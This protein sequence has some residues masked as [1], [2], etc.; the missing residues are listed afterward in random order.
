MDNELKQL[1]EE[2]RGFRPLAVPA[3]LLERIEHDLAP[4]P[5]RWK[6]WIPI[7]VLFAVAVVALVLLREPSVAKN[8]A[9]VFQPV[10]ARSTVVT[11]TDDGYLT[12]SDGSLVKRTRQSAV[13]TVTWKDP[14]SRASLTWSVPR[15]DVTVTPVSFQ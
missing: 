10:S 14:A 4:R 9:P 11:A 1:E 3:A 6:I 15:E 8:G 12:L 5:R 2:L 13:D 7:P